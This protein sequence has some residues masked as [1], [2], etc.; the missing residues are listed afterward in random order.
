MISGFLVQNGSEYYS[1]PVL[2]KVYHRLIL[3][4]VHDHKDIQNTLF[5]IPMVFGTIFHK[6]I[7]LDLT[8][9]TFDLHLT[10]DISAC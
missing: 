10:H 6:T 8:N 5:I 7:L 1:E 3:T 9:I 2:L 4:S